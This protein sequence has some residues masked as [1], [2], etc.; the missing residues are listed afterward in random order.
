MSQQYNQFRAMLAISRASF[1]AI[2]RSPSTVV[3]SIF[4][5]LIFILVF[6]FIGN[7]GGPTYKV[8]MA[9]ASDTLNPIVDS[10]KQY[11]SVRFVKYEDPADLEADLVKGRITG[12]LSIQKEPKQDS[13]ASYRVRFQSTTAS[14]DKFA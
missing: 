10:L 13:A 11:S 9:P 1:K 5:P 14:A 8:V 2:M 3:F 7:S 6:G 12:I 4:F